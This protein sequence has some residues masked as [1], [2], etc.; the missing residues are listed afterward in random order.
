MPQWHVDIILSS[1]KFRVLQR[2]GVWPKQA[3]NV[4]WGE[5]CLRQGIAHQPC[6]LRLI[7]QWS[8]YI[9]VVTPLDWVAHPSTISIPRG[10][11]FWSY[12]SLDPLSHLAE[13]SHCPS[14]HRQSEKVSEWS[15]K[16]YYWP[17][18]RAPTAS[19]SEKWSSLIN[20]PATTSDSC[21]RWWELRRLLTLCRRP[22][23]LC[24]IMCDHSA[25]RWG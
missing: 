8:F 18:S 3:I 21:K 12:R 2:L 20:V 5:E 23:L 10:P 7:R 16:D 24:Y 13:D 9:N 1:H 19:K 17:T 14:W 6:H 22:K 25:R 11:N 4:N 15:E